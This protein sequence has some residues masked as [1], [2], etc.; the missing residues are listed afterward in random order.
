MQGLH[1]YGVTHS[2]GSNKVLNGAS[3]T[4]PAGELVCLLGPSGCGKSTILRL[5]GGLETLQE[6]NIVI[7]GETV[8]NSDMCLPPEKRKI[9]LMFQDYALFPHL[10]I[11]AN[12]TFGLH[13]M[14]KKKAQARA[15]DMLDQVGMTA[16]A[17]AF[18][19]MLSG[20]QQQ[21][22]ALARALAPEP[23]L[24]LLD[25][26]FSGLDTNMREKIRQETLSVLRDAGVA[27]LMVTHDPE[28]A[29]YMADRIKILGRG[30]KILQ[31]G[32][33][34]EIY[35]NP[36]DEFVANLFGMMNR[37]E[38]VVENGYVDTPLG[39]VE[40]KKIADGELVQVLVRPEGILFDTKQ[41]E[42][43]VKV[44]VVSNHLLG[45]SSIVRMRVPDGSDRGL[46]M[47]GRVHR[48]FTPELDKE[49]WARIDPVNAFIFPLKSKEQNNNQ[50]QA[51][52]KPV[53]AQ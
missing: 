3:L 32:S 36:A 9:G 26:P 45:H 52:I 10:D 21:R 13:G 2:Y 35:Y 18:P 49:T 40:C 7:D 47:D 42:N 24:L 29:M 12:V 50:P 23:K 44:D 30:G 4:I 41:S 19:H 48:E 17:E 5:A 20:G 1:I 34:N 53:A 39:K 8:A 22:I 37:I 51:E 43:A 27:T 25:E 46:M 28:E 15:L 33:P 31:A 38:G 14:D 6:G 16:Y 11:M